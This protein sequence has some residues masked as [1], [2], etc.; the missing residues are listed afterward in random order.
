MGEPCTGCGRCVAI[1]PG[2]A[3]T[4]VDYRKNS[5]IPLVTIPLEMGPTSVS[6]G[7]KLSVVSDSGEELGEFEVHSVKE[8]SKYRSTQLVRLMIPKELAAR[9][10]GFYLQQREI[11]KPMDEYHPAPLADT[12]IICRCERVTAGEIRKWI[13]RGVRDINQLKAL[14]R[15]GMGACGAKTCT[16]LVERLI[17]EEDVPVKKYTPGTKRPLFVEVPLGVFSGAKDS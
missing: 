16:S 5:E 2:L 12:A 15:V 17:R 9:A 7:E 8:L 11:S 6:V 13:K 14:T 1:C 10:A 4:L 3:I